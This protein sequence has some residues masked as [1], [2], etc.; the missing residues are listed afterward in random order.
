MSHKYKYKFVNSSGTKTEIVTNYKLTKDDLERYMKN[1]GNNVT[2]TR[3][4]LAESLDCDALSEAN[5]VITAA[6]FV[7]M[8]VIEN[9]PSFG[10]SYKAKVFK[11][12]LK[13]LEEL[14]Q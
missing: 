12:Y 1:A 5:K 6:G 7:C 4:P 13:A 2:Y 3:E 14:E 11:T 10:S 8:P 9:R